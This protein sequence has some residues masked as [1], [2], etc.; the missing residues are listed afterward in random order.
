MIAPFF[1]GYTGARM[2][3]QSVRDLRINAAT[4]A[5]LM[6][7]LDDDEELGRLDP[8]FLT[9]HGLARMAESRVL[10]SAGLTSAGPIQSAHFRRCVTLG[11]DAVVRA[12]GTDDRDWF[13][14]MLAWGSG[15]ASWCK[16][17]EETLKMCLREE[18]L[19]TREGAILG[20]WLLHREKL[21]KPRDWAQFST[22]AGK[23]LDYDFGLPDGELE[24]VRMLQLHRSITRGTPGG[25]FV[26]RDDA[27]RLGRRQMRDRHATAFKQ[28]RRRKDRPE[29]VEVVAEEQDKNAVE[30]AQAVMSVE[31]VR[32]VQAIT[33]ARQADAKEGSGRDLVLRNFPALLEGSLSIRALA[34][35]NRRAHSYLNRVFVKEKQAIG[36]EL[37]K[38]GISLGG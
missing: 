16:L 25:I 31:A 33:E 2:L 23:V 29:P 17:T 7:E 32:K 27:V 6:R 37:K 10:P 8:I 19:T 21:G 30:A 11:L 26:G 5:D 18:P 12:L 14:E 3:P 36:R 35:A 24:R 15:F 20:Y 34:E 28:R 13:R 4:T 22:A 38:L 9:I 1:R